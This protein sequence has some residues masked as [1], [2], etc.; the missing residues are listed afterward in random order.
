L[1]RGKS[2]RLIGNLTGLLA[3]LKGLPL[4]YNRD[5]QED[6]EPLFDSAEQVTLAVAA[7]T[8]M[9]ATAMFVPDAMQAAADEETMAATDLA[10][11][12]VRAGT[13]FRDAHAI[14]GAHVRAALAGDGALGDL[15]A[16]DP[17]LGPEAA[18]LVGP[19]VGVTMRT[20]RGA[21]GPQA[22]PLQLDSY[23]AMLA[24]DQER[25]GI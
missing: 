12:L 22:L 20:S 9:I 25:L 23:R 24:R 4:A 2:G 5:L 11:H 8:G 14:V 18:A 3:T 10:E 16:A 6:K 1:A 19:G 13:P 21:A 15:V 7:L 17:R